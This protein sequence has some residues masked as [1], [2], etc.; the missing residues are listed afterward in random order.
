MPLV[1]QESVHAKP[2]QLPPN[3][4]EI[5]TIWH[6]LPASIYSMVNAQLVRV[7]NISIPANIDFN[8]VQLSDIHIGSVS[9]TFLERITQPSHKSV[10]FAL[11]P[12]LS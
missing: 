1:S 12:H 6:K 2:Q 10:D 9:N 7:K 5:A 4:A 8:V 11:W 3:L